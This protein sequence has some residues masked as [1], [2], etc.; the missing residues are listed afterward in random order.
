MPGAV[1]ASTAGEA[2]LQ[3]SCRVLE[4]P[5]VFRAF[6]ANVETDLRLMVR[7]VHR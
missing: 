6:G 2:I 4:Q 7:P 3:G 1:A 5:L